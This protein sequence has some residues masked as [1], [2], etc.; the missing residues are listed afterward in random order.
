MTSKIPLNS[1][2]RKKPSVKFKN[3]INSLSGARELNADPKQKDTLVIIRTYVKRVNYLLIHVQ[4]ILRLF[5]LHKYELNEQIP[6]IDGEKINMVCKALYI[7]NNGFKGRQP[8]GENLDF[9]KEMSSF[10]DSHYKELGCDRIDGSNLSRIIGNLEQVMVANIENNIK[11]H[12]NKYLAKYIRMY[13]KSLNNKE[14]NIKQLCPVIFKDIING[15]EFKSND[16]FHKWINDNRNRI[17]P[18]SICNFEQ[19]NKKKNS[20]YN[21]NLQLDT[22]PQ[23]FIKYM[24]YITKELEMNNCKKMQF[25]PLKTSLIMN[26]IPFDSLTLLDITNIPNKSEITKNINTFKDSLWNIYFQMNNRIFRPNKHKFDYCISTDGY[27]ASLRFITNETFHISQNTK[28][29]KVQGI[30]K[31]AK[32]NK[33]EK[34]KMKKENKMKMDNIKKESSE[35]KLLISREY[36]EIYDM[37]KECKRETNKNLTVYLKSIKIPKVKYKKLLKLERME[38]KENCSNSKV[39]F[40]LLCHKYLMCESY[41]MYLVNEMSNKAREFDLKINRTEINKYRIEFE[42]SYYKYMQ[43]KNNFNILSNTCD[44]IFKICSI[45]KRFLY[46]YRDIINDAMNQNK[47]LNNTEIYTFC[48]GTFQKFDVTSN[49]CNFYKDLGIS[50]QSMRQLLG[51]HIYTIR[52]LKLQYKYLYFKKCCREVILSPI[53]IFY[54]QQY[55]LLDHKS[56]YEELIE[57]DIENKECARYI[58]E[59]IHNLILRNILF[60]KFKLEKTRIIEVK[61]NTKMIDIIKK[62]KYSKNTVDTSYNMSKSA[63]IESFDNGYPYIFEDGNLKYYPLNIFMKYYLESNMNT[64]M[65]YLNNS[66]KNEKLYRILLSY[67]PLMFHYT[68]I[69]DEHFI[70]IKHGIRYTYDESINKIDINKLDPLQKKMYER[71]NKCE[72]TI[73]NLLRMHIEILNSIELYDKYIY[74]KKCCKN[75][76]CRKDTICMNIILDNI[77]DDDFKHE[78]RKTLK[79]DKSIKKI[80]FPYFNKVPNIDEELKSHNKVY[81]DPGKHKLLSMMDDSGKK[82]NY[83]H[84]ERM[85]TTKQLKYRY[86]LRQ[87]MNKSGITKIEKELSNYDSKSCIFEKFKLYIKEKNRLYPL[88]AKKYSNKIFSKL[89]WYSVINKRRADKKIIEKIKDTYGSDCIL[90]YGDWSCRSQLRN[91]MPT[92]LISLKRN[93]GKEIKIYNIDEYRTS[94]IHHKTEDTCE[95]LKLWVPGKNGKYVFKSFHSVL[96]YKMLGIEKKN[97]KEHKDDG[98]QK[99]IKEKKK[100]KRKINKPKMDSSI[101]CINRDNNAVHNMRRIVHEWIENKSIPDKW[102]R[103]NQ[104]GDIS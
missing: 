55:T 59:N 56:R 7:N 84:K 11:S 18:P 90:I 101:G 20:I 99:E 6:V 82:L 3:D 65:N 47:N 104:L 53:K 92:P 76:T 15:K 25:L 36:K 60:K 69:I 102:N 23:Q 100:R 97:D 70:T 68:G 66:G 45:D 87:Y 50:I 40:A 12:F 98:E 78:M 61:E 73:N 9:Y 71:F 44:E 13:L 88:L 83:T 33:E 24:I 63:Y 31:Y 21:Y 62:Y 77:Y 17:L 94:I 75:I 52:N 16:R 27:Y 26:Y 96:T 46:E 14:I 89:K 91:S 51:L 43:F 35:K 28:D 2:I 58:L 81:V 93:I 49:I 64:Y 85:K 29:R 8:I 32:L 10:Y 1:I 67:N 74:F 37:I 30:K 80:E 103:K 4:Q 72:L 39:K 79:K 54:L 5:M 48:T 41:G 57:D 95:N 38:K 19:V 22:L 34:D 42:E 86:K